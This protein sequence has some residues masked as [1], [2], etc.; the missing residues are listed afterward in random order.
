[1][2]QSKSYNYVGPNSIRVKASG[3]PSGRPIES[4]EELARWISEADPSKTTDGRT[5]ATFVIDPE[6]RLCLADRRSEHVA[7]SGGRP[8]RSAGEMFFRAEGGR[9]VIEE[10]SNHSTG[11]C[12]E[13]ES[14]GEVEEALDRIGIDHPGRFTTEV[15]FRRCPAC[16]E[17]NIV[18]DNW[19][20]CQLCGS[21]LPRAWNFD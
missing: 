19:Y 16:G 4:P 11:F 13:P 1:V 20:E 21:E 7:C 10:A 12:P 17:R 9:I 18:K 3:S 15:V 8:V 14:W 2:N 6:G 5:A